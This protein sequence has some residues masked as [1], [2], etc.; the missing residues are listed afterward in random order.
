MRSNIPL[1]SQYCYTRYDPTFAARARQMKETAGGSIIIG[2]EN[3]GQ[4]SSREH[5]AINP[6][7][8]GVKCVIAKS[9][10]R[11]HKGNLINHGIIPMLFVNPEDYDRISQEDELEVTDFIRQLRSRVITFRDVTKGFDFQ[12][13]LEMSDND[14]DI[15]IDGGQLQHLKRQLREMG[16]IR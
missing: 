9:I 2:G 1:M 16:K 8:L 12:V 6:M 14:L 13:R 3:Y 10:A 11:I 7:Y 4:G 15:I 5:A